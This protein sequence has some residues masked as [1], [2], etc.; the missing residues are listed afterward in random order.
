MHMTSERPQ[1]TE[2]EQKEV[3]EHAQRVSAY[4][5]LR[6]LVRQWRMEL[7]FQ[8]KADYIV[9]RALGGLVAAMAIVA[10]LYFGYQIFESFISS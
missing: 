1:L 10:G 9:A 8:K 3:R 2:A 7:A 5:M 4:F 6:K